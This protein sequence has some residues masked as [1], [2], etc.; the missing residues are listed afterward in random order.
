MGAYRVLGTK[1]VV[2]EA[3]LSSPHS[4]HTKALC[5]FNL[6]EVFASVSSSQ[7]LPLSLPSVQ[8]R[9]QREP[10]APLLN[11]QLISWN[12]PSS[13]FLPSNS[14]P[15]TLKRGFRPSRLDTTSCCYSSLP[16]T[17]FR[18]HWSLCICPTHCSDQI[19]SLSTLACVQI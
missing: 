18:E 16:S 8:C 4:P 17:R 6:L 9:S 10:P 13:P 5:P 2:R 14:P 19:R 12:Y 1:P 15:Q 11:Q 3:A 7:A